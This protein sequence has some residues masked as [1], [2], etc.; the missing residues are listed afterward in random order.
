MIAPPFY[1][2]QLDV[3]SPFVAHCI[4]GKRSRI[5]IFALVI[6]CVTTGAVGIYALEKEDA[7]SI[8]KAVIRHSCRYGFPSI[9]F[10]DK[11]SGIGKA[12][13]LKVILR[14]ATDQLSRQIGLENHFKAVQSHGERGRVER[15]IKTIRSMLAKTIVT[16]TKNSVM[17]W[18]TIFATVANMINN[19]PI[20]RIAS[21]TTSSRGEADEIL[22]PNRILLGRNNFR[23]LE[24]IDR[25]GTNLDT[26]M[27]KNHNIQKLFYELLLKNIFELVPQPKW[28][29]NDRDLNIGDIV[30]FIYKESNYTTDHHWRLGRVVKILSD[31]KPTK[32]IIEY[33]NDKETT[34][35]QTERITR[36]LVVIH[37]H[38]DLDYHSK[39]HQE[40]M[41]TLSHFSLR[42][43]KLEGTDVK[44]VVLY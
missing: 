1:A 28:F 27:E 44:F 41:F 11:G 43:Q 25:S 42:F 15:V 23:S 5:P 37:K 2:I 35:R 14:S 19:V 8:V 13:K 32:V 4:H 33:K 10:T 40:V 31:Q 29:R 12:S 7:R 24:R 3:C 38:D 36:E 26:V 9:N 20:A 30:L 6:I 39:A 21:S 22:T 18:E 16:Q 34:F 17:G